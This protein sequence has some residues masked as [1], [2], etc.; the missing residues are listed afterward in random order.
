M[1]GFFLLIYFIRLNLGKFILIDCGC[2][3]IEL[4]IIIVLF[5]RLSFGIKLILIGNCRFEKIL[6]FIVG[7]FDLCVILYFFFF[8][9]FFVMDNVLFIKDLN[10]FFCNSLVLINYVFWFI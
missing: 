3:V 7:G 8:K 4:G 1:W 6:M 2:V 5:F 10:I 9:L